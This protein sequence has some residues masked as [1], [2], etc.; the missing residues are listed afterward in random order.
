MEVT[1]VD[2]SWWGCFHASLTL[3]RALCFQ[4]PDDIDDGDGYATDENDFLHTIH[5]GPDP[6]LLD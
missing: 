4:Y 6:Q 2:A 5:L 1:T 3:E